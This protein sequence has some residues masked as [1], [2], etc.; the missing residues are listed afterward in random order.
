MWKKAKM[1]AGVLGIVGLA[2]VA[3]A[4]FLYGSGGFVVIAPASASVKTTVDGKEVGTVAPGA[5]QKFSLSQGA[6]AVTLTDSTGRSSS[7]QLK[8]DNGM[9]DRTLPVG[10]Q[11]FAVF[12]VTNYWYQKK[13]VLD[14]LAAKVDRGIVVKSRYTDAAPFDTPSNVYYSTDE[15]PKS[16]KQGARTNL[17]LE[18]PCQLARGP[19]QQLIGAVEF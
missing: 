7:Y 18:V 2:G 13:K 17:L 10:A 15:L 1:I 16:I 8:V 4:A 3:G 6:H 11:C 14:K 19:D 9:F 5:H 12:D